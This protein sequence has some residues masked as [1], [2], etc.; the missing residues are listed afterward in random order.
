MAR[1]VASALDP[2]TLPVTG[3]AEV[4]FVGR[5]NVGKSSL[6]G[7]VLGQPKLVRTSR[8]PGRTQALNLFLSGDNLAVVDLPGYGYAK[9]SKD[10]RSRIERMVRNYLLQRRALCGVVLL[11]D[12]RRQEVVDSDLAM[13]QWV[14][15]AGRQLLLVVTKADL[16]PKNQLGNVV[17]SIEARFGVPRG[18]VLVCSAKTGQGRQELLA[19]LL[20]L[21]RAMPKTEAVV[22]DGTL[23]S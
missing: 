9:L 8:T 7:L 19:L 3:C 1:F 23:T 13:A 20:E 11:V 2:K 15:E 16:V 17:R 14:T 21:A 22:E 5:S 4:A 12:A 6:L 10:Q 18:T